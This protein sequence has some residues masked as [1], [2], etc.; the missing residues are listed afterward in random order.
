MAAQS[1][2]AVLI[3]E[4]ES[5]VK[6]FRDR[7]DPSA[8]KG[9]PAH[10]T[11]LFPFKPPQDLTPALGRELALLFSGCPRFDVSFS[12][13]GRF[14]DALYLA[15][16]P[17][18]PFRR[19]TQLITERFPQHPPYEG[20]FPQTIPHLTIAQLP[21]LEHLDDI[22][23][24]FQRSAHGHLPILASIKDVALM[25]NASGRWQVHSRF[26]LAS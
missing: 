22:T 6:P 12:N 7:F 18:D 24:D 5:L 4:A 16:R 26:D 20:E 9:M 10:V 3:P 13:L 1:A 23:V 21:E 8:A 11:I 2:L 17:E 25:D 14:P 15:P 19:L